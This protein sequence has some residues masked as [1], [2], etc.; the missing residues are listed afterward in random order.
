MFL[1]FPISY[2]S[3]AQ[4]AI[5]FPALYYEFYYLYDIIISSYNDLLTYDINFDRRICDPI[6][7]LYIYIYIFKY[8]CGQ[9]LYRYPMAS[10]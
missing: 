5:A 3:N 10:A 9:L 7:S 4:F 8:T 1:A 6:C 2:L